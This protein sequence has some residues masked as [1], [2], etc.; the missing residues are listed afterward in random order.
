MPPPT[1]QV[2]V[3]GLWCWSMAITF[4]AGH[5]YTNSSFCPVRHLYV[6]FQVETKQPPS[7]LYL[8]TTT[9]LLSP[10][11]WW[12]ALRNWFSGTSKTT[13]LP[14]WS[15]TRM[16]SELTEDA[17]PTAL[18]S[19]FT[20]PENYN[21]HNRMLFVEF[22]AFNTISAMKLI[23]ELNILDLSATLFNWI[24]DLLTNWVS[25]RRFRLAITASLQ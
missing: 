10:P 21:N 23:G 17:I 3:P 9:M 24:L 18:H 12:S 11:S 13:S 8:M 22:S 5:H 1:C 25:L 7:F 6:K 4:F 2:A 20:Q 19:V 16:L 15:L 14:A